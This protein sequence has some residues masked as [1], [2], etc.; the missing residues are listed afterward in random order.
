MSFRASPS[1]YYSIEGSGSGSMLPISFQRAST[2]EPLRHSYADYTNRARSAT[3]ASHN[4]AVMLMNR[5]QPKQIPRNTRAMTAPPSQQP[6]QMAAFPYLR[7]M[8]EANSNGATQHIP[9][10]DIS[11]NDFSYNFGTFASSSIDPG[12][13]TDSRTSSPFTSFDDAMEDEA[14]YHSSAHVSMAS[15]SP[16]FN[17]S[18]ANDADVQYMSLEEQVPSSGCFE[19]YYHSNDAMMVDPVCRANEL[20]MKEEEDAMK[21]FMNLE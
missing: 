17:T 4:V 9:T 11:G 8:L 6:T 3:P 13:C 21:M 16:Y 5:R 14:M 20:A 18:C 19:N 7:T 12:L 15:D 2:A 1:P 10:S